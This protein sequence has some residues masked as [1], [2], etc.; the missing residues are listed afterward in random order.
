MKYFIKGF[1]VVDSK[2][3]AA[4]CT[5]KEKSTCT[6]CKTSFSRCH[7]RKFCHVLVTVVAGV[8]KAL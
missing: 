1:H 2:W 4:K 7:L 8:A 5:K 6:T 3:T